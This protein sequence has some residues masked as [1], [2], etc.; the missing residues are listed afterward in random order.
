M[1]RAGHGQG[2]GLA[3]QM[4]RHGPGTHRE[5]CITLP[6]RQRGLPLA[7]ITPDNTVAWRGMMNETLSGEKTRRTGAAVL[8]LPGQR[9]D[10]S[11]DMPSAA[12][13][14]QSGAGRYITQDPS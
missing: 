1:G 13:V 10:E 3:E 6:L 12:P 5:E 7:L 14:L 9:Y 2:C 4:A 8:R 11:G